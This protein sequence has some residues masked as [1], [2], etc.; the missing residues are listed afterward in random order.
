MVTISKGLPLNENA[1]EYLD[2]DAIKRIKAEEGKWK[3]AKISSYQ[4]DFS[5]DMEVNVLNKSKDQSD[6]V[7]VGGIP[8]INTPTAITIGDKIEQLTFIGSTLDEMNIKAE[9]STIVTAESEL[10]SSD[11]QVYTYDEVKTV[12]STM[13]PA[14]EDE[15]SGEM[16]DMS[17]SGNSIDIVVMA[18]V[19]L[20]LLGI[21][22]RFILKRREKRI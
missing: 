6:V 18:V 15:S 17:A 8:Y 11:N 4:D 2:E 3:I 10:T 14:V 12:L 13:N 20:I 1:K 9:S 22:V 21:I 5:Y 16:S 7:I 19:G